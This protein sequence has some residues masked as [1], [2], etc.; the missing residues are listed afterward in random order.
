MRKV[1]SIAIVL[2]SFV[3][4]SAAQRG[5]RQQQPRHDQGRFEIRH[6][7]RNEPRRE[8]HQDNRHDRRNSRIERDDH[9]FREDGRPQ[10]RHDTRGWDHRGYHWGHGNARDHWDG[11][12]FDRGYYGDHWGPRNRFYWGHCNWYGPRFYPGSYFWYNGAYFVII[13]QAPPYW[14]D[15][16]VIIIEDDGWYYMVNPQYPGIRIHVDVRF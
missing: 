5:Q 12:R 3:G 9:S 16:E 11:R 13:E 15:D 14:Y 7:Q 1:L 4:V 10:E 8:T 6:E 2:L